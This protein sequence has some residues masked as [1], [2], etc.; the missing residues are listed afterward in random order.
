MLLARLETEKASLQTHIAAGHALL[1]EPHVPAF[2]KV[3][4][5][6]LEGMLEETETLTG[7]KRE[8]LQV[9]PAANVRYTAG[10]AGDCFR[11]IIT[12]RYFLLLS[13]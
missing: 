10:C 6:D 4:I 12:N 9:G 1:Q 7:R 5:G 3:T 13:W 2:V 11:S 8:M